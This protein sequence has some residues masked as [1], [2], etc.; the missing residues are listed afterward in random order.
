MVP[1]RQPLSGG[2]AYQSMPLAPPYLC[3]HP[4]AKYRNS[5]PRALPWADIPR[6]VGAAAQFS[7]ITDARRLESIQRTYDP[8]RQL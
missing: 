4:S 1:F 5:R 6:A 7:A 2:D 8:A 3:D